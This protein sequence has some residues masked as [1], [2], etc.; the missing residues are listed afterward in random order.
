MFESLIVDGIFQAGETW[1][2]LIDDYINALALPASAF[3]SC[4][5]GLP[6]TTGLVGGSSGGDLEWKD[7][8][9]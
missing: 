9:P 3:S 8:R 1:E 6:C 2:F 7:L 5:G 4:A